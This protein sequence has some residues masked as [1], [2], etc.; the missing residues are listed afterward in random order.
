MFSNV[1]PY[2]IVI[3]FFF[4]LAPFILCIVSLVDILRSEFAGNNKIVWVLV[5]I[6]LPF[7]GAIMYFTIGRKQKVLL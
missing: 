2:E 6:L 7:V 3:M 5:V 4:M 1:G